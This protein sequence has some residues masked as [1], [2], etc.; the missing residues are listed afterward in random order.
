MNV[1]G[2][3][4]QSRGNHAELCGCYLDISWRFGGGLVEVWWRFDGG[5]VKERRRETRRKGR[6]T[7]RECCIW[8]EMTRIKAPYS[9]SSE[10]Y[11]R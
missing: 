3:T 11:C 7:G 1:A 9:S 6:I 4:R 8:D 5:L 2:I 10:K